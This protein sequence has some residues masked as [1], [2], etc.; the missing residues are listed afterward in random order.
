MP[1]DF[2]PAR[3]VPLGPFEPKVLRTMPDERRL[4]EGFLERVLATHPVWPWPLIE[5]EAQRRAKAVLATMR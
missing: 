2:P 4:I 3:A 1:N 5:E